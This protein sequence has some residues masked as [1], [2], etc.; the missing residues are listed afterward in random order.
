MRK[1]S[2]VISFIFTAGQGFFQNSNSSS[3]IFQ[4]SN[5]ESSVA[6]C[7]QSGSYEVG[8][9][10]EGENDTNRL[11]VVFTQPLQ[12]L[13]LQTF[14]KAGDLRDPPK[15]HLEPETNWKK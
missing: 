15:V 7:P 3:K 8:E 1:E 9:G 2:R 4:Y 10:G 5:R 12:L 13:F 6:V 11:C 14:G